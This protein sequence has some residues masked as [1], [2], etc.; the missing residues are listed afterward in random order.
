MASQPDSI[1]RLLVGFA[2]IRDWLSVFEQTS[3]SL[4]GTSSDFLAGWCIAMQRLFEEYGAV[5]ARRPWEIYFIDLRDIFCMD[6][7]VFGNGLE[8]F[9]RDYGLT[10]LREADMHLDKYQSPRPLQDKK[11]SHLQLQRIHLNEINA[12]DESIFL[13]H[14]ERRD[15]YVWGFYSTRANSQHLFVQHSQTGQ[16]LPPVVDY[17]GDPDRNYVLISHE[18]SPD[19][20]HLALLYR[21][22]S[23]KPNEPL[24]NRLVTV[25]WRIDETMSFKRRMNCETWAR[26]V[27]SHELDTALFGDQSRAVTFMNDRSCVTPSGMLDLQTGRRQPLPDCLLHEVVSPTAA[28]GAFFSCNGQQLFISELV[29]TGPSEQDRP[30]TAT[31]IAPFEPSLF[32]KYSWKDGERRMVDVSPSGRY[33]VLDSVIG[34]DMN[35]LGDGALYVYDTESSETIELPFSER[36]QYWGAQFQFSRHETRLIAFLRG[37]GAGAQ[38]LFVKIWDCL[39]TTPRL[40]SHTKFCVGYTSLPQTIHIHKAGNSAVGVSSTKSIQRI[41]LSNEIKFLD[42][43]DVTENY[44]C[45]IS[46]TSS[47]GSHVAFVKYGGGG[48]QVQIM[49]LTSLQAPARRLKLERP[50]SLISRHLSPGSKMPGGL[51]PDLGVLVVDAEV[52]DLT[53]DINGALIP[54]TIEDLP[55]LLEFYRSYW[56]SR[57]LRCHV[58][59]CKS[60]VVYVNEGDQW[61]GP[62]FR[63]CILLFRIDL[64]SRTSTRIELE[65]PQKLV[66]PSVTFHPSL[67]LMTLSYASPSP[68]ELEVIQDKAPSLNL[69]IVG[70]RSSEMTSLAIPESLPTTAIAE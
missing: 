49:D 12:A 6:R 11:P 69:A 60:Y 30:F 1:L 21:I 5:L 14:D 27:F 70:L 62:E 4:H 41:E 63:A 56:A 9:Y 17:N 32:V 34:T 64:K 51:S 53:M 48:G 66:S 23:F 36:L 16:R 37:Q 42:A 18:M 47:D 44:P 29:S 50:Q 57:R 2:E 55:A 10:P 28:I 35:D 26:V 8:R 45:E 38:L 40:T 7:S 22:G 25:I 15:V 52:F 65:I 13:V 39:A 24:V 20:R 3:Q 61:D 68:A 43:V 33:L 46:T 59:P 19:G 67:P 54:F 31:K 58:S